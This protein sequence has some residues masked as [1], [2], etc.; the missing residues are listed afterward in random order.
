MKEEKGSL[1][2]EAERGQVYRLELIVEL[3]P[4]EL[5]PFHQG[6]IFGHFV[7]WSEWRRAWLHRIAVTVDEHVGP[8]A[9]DLQRFPIGKGRRADCAQGG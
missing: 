7:V 2:G 4:R 9:Q 3:A 1:K 8:L 6:R 5:R